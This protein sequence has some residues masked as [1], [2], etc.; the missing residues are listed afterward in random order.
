MDTFE[1]LIPD[2]Y[3]LRIKKTI[4]HSFLTN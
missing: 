3:L 2:K 1:G 4:K